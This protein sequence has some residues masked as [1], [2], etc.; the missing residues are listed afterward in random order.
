M[1]KFLSKLW[2]M[3][4]LVAVSV[5][6]LGLYMYMTIRPVSYG[7]WYTYS[8]TTEESGTQYTL[9]MSIKFIDEKR[10]VI[11]ISSDDGS[12]ETNSWYVKNG[13]QVLINGN[14]SE[15]SKSEEEF[16]AY[17]EDLRNNEEMWNAVWNGEDTIYGSVF[18]V[19]A[20][21]LT[22]HT[23]TP[24]E[25]E[26]EAMSCSGAVW[27]AVVMGIVE[28][29]LVTFA[30]LSVIYYI[31]GKKAVVTT[32]GDTQKTEEIANLE[33]VEETPL[34]DVESLDK[35]EEKKEE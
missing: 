24:V 3:A 6:L 31:K 7:M 1:K 10:L 16:D 35:A 14:M 17:L 8:Q 18:Y 23:A 15:E 34:T 5:V 12:I 19:N 20:F 28:V 30:V 25:G 9:E 26:D 2:V 21:K 4:T 13:G 22:P 27:Y 11:K 32:S 33:K 29:A